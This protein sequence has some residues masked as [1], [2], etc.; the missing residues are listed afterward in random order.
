VREKFA[1]NYILLYGFYEN[2]GELEDNS[3]EL[4]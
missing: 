4:E 1:V 3:D 2:F